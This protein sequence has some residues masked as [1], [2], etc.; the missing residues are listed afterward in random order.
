MI[1]IPCTEQAFISDFIIQA[2]IKLKTGGPRLQ[3]ESESNYIQNC[4]QKN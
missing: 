4:V 2:Y 1:K 3:S